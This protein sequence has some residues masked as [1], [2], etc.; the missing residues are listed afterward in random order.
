MGC[1]FRVHYIREDRG[2]R[3]FRMFEKQNEIEPVVIFRIER[4]ESV[5]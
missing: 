4:V 5:D 3:D 2:V 1:M